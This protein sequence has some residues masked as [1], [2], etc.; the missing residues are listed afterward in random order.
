[1]KE[2]HILNGDALKSQLVEQGGQQIVLRECLIEGDTK[3]GSMEEVFKSRT[4]FFENTYGIKEQEYQETSIK[5]ISKIAS[6]NTPSIINLWFE[7][8][9]FCQVNCWFAVSILNQLD[10]KHQV[11]LVSPISKSWK[12][13]G[14]LTPDQLR[15]SYDNRKELSREEQRRINTL[16]KAFQQSDW[17][18]LRENAKQLRHV[19]EQI[20]EVVESH[21]ARFPKKD[22]PGR[23]Q[24]SIQNIIA[25][26][27]EADFGKVFQAFCEKEG[28]YGFGDLQVKRI[29]EEMKATNKR[30]HIFKKET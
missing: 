10:H 17:E 26:L 27:G 9:L 20:E 7:N 13:F 4:L 11:Y 14:E 29:M 22:Q 16:W 24:Q 8:D 18:L 19:I 12:G 25:D 28:I 1:M 6:I 3:G 23:P 30:K 5:E 15:A 2:Y 21:I